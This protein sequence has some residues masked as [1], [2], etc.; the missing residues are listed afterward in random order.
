MATS[1]RVRPGQEKLE[2][3]QAWQFSGGWSTCAYYMERV[4][5]ARLVGDGLAASDL[6]ALITDG[7]V[8][9][10]PKHIL[11][12]VRMFYLDRIGN[13]REGYA[14]KLRISVHTLDLHLE[15]AYTLIEGMWDAHH[16]AAMRKNNFAL[17]EK[18]A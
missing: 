7:F 5:N 17:N 6:E 18:A 4:D 8:C 13:S 2:R 15:T 1:K 9:Q 14:A 12:S 11:R 16:L 10:L 3:W